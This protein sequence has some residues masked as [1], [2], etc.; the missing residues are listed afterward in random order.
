MNVT[1]CIELS[2]LHNPVLKEGIPPRGKQ[3]LSEG[4][5]AAAVTLARK[6]MT[7]TEL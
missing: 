1:A 7:A 3:E 5:R 6:D 4:L 2:V